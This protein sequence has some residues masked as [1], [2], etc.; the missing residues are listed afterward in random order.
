MT[1]DDKK[2]NPKKSGIGLVQDFIENDTKDILQKLP[3]FK[4]VTEKTENMIK[5]KIYNTRWV[6]LL[7]RGHFL[8]ILYSVKMAF[9]VPFLNVFWP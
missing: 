4:N 2:Q 7:R 9:L 3:G 5:Y 8:V 6:L 1:E